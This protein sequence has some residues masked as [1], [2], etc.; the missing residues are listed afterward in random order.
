MGKHFVTADEPKDVGGNDLGPTPNQLLASSFAACT[1]MTLRMYAN[2]KGLDVKEIK[3]HVNYSK[4][5][6]DDAGQNNQP[7][8]G[9]AS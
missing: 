9:R 7:G 5:H 6:S 8:G 2:R 3:V 1:A 4:R